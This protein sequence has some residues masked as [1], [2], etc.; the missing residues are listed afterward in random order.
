MATMDT[1]T[2]RRQLA[3]LVSRV[4]FTKERITLTRYGKACAALVPLEDL[5]ELCKRAPRRKRSKAR[6]ASSP[7][8]QI[9][10]KQTR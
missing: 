1:A 8:A 9:P 2:A 6:A 4:R 10:E 7:R 5:D 3:D